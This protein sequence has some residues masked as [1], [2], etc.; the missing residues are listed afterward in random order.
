MRTTGG[1]EGNGGDDQ[2][3]RQDG[4]HVLHGMDRAVDAAVQHR[5]LDLLGEQRLA[6]HLQQ[7]PILDLIARG[8]DD[9]QGGH[10]LG[11]LRRGA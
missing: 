1:C 7:A 10:L 5:L 6:A 9:D 3:R 11:V 8:A 2:T 4:G